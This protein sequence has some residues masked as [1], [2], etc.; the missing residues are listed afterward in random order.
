MNFG[1]IYTRF[2]HLHINLFESVATAPRTLRQPGR[3]AKHLPLAHC[4]PER[5]RRPLEQTYRGATLRQN[6]MYGLFHCVGILKIYLKNINQT[7]SNLM[8][9]KGQQRADDKK[10]GRK[11]NEHGQL[12]SRENGNFVMLGQ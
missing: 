1:K 12:A 11:D 4:Q 9:E 2:W 8:G 3:H 5:V 10:N 7:K 6:I